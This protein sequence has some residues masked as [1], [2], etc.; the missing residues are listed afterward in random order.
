MVNLLSDSSKEHLP[1]PNPQQMLKVKS[2]ENKSFL[3][4]SKVQ[5]AN[6]ILLLQMHSGEK[7]RTMKFIWDIL[8]RIS[9][10]II[11]SVQ[12]PILYLVVQII[13]SGKT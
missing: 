7:E 2:G 1:A 4:F 8:F 9:F 13:R 5:N 10:N 6:C 11:G 12:K 3:V